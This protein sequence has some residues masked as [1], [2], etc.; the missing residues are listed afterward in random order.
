M[1]HADAGLQQTDDPAESLQPVQ[2]ACRL[3]DVMQDVEQTEEELVPG[4][5]HK[6]HGLGRVVDPEDGVSREVDCLVTG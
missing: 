2:P 5:H 4:A 3:L 1:H 6:Q